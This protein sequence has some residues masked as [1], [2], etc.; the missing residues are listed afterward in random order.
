MTS[1]VGP[2]FDTLSSLRII[3]FDTLIGGPITTFTV[4]RDTVWVYLESIVHAA[5][6]SRVSTPVVSK[7]TAAIELC[8]ADF[9][10]EERRRPV[11]RRYGPTG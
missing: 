6:I 10:D 2:H 8:P 5:S 9:A 4:E 1:L 11:N 7:L 3:Y